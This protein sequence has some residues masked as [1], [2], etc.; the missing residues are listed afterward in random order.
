MHRQTNP[1]FTP[2]IPSCS[3]SVGSDLPNSGLFRRAAHPEGAAP[4]ARRDL[5]F[6]C[7]VA[8]YPAASASSFLLACDCHCR[9]RGQMHVVL[10]GGGGGDNGS[11]AR[12]PVSDSAVWELKDRSGRERSEL[13]RELPDRNEYPEYYILIKAPL[14]A[15]HSCCRM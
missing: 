1:F 13:F 11:L 2:L 3:V 8:S 14:S 4:P 15:S 10:G 7:G 5:R 6:W 12:V 9:G